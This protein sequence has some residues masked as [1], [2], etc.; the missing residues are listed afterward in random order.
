MRGYD[1]GLT[2]YYFLIPGDKLP[3]HCILSWLCRHRVS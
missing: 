1:E 2:C 3:A